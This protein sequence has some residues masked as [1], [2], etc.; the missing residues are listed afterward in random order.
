MSESFRQ[1]CQIMTDAINLES[2]KYAN[3]LTTVEDVA[4]LPEAIQAFELTL[5]MAEIN[6][7]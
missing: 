4:K 1:F 5:K 7:K 6:A 3:G 2:M